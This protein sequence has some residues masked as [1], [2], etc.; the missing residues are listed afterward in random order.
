[1]VTFINRHFLLKEKAVAGGKI[2]YSCLMH[3]R[4]ILSLLYFM[5]YTAAVWGVPPNYA[6]KDP[7]I[8]LSVKLWNRSEM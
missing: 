5:H 2:C 1:M 4:Q 7:L 8:S 3:A 6:C